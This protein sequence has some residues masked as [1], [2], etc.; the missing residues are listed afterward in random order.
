MS[1]AKCT[2][3]TAALAWKHAHPHCAPT[4]PA[5][6]AHADVVGAPWWV[7]PVTFLQVLRRHLSFTFRRSGRGVT[8]RN[9]IAA[10]TRRVG[11]LVGAGTE[12]EDED[13]ADWEP[14]VIPQRCWCQAASEH[15]TVSAF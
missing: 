3:S 1:L 8:W 10:Q 5:H 15:G 9:V 2:F 13:E 4:G 12:P 6:S 11:R 7:F 14:D